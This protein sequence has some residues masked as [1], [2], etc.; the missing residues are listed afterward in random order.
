MSGGS[1]E[2]VYTHICQAAQDVAHI[3]EKTKKRD[4]GDFDFDANRMKDMTAEKLKDQVVSLMEK[5]VH[6]L[7]EAEVYA[8]RVEWLDSG[9][10]G[11]DSFVERTAEELHEVN[12]TNLE[13]EQ[14]YDYD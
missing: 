9:D 5:A 6:A 10:D 3:L 11:F 7:R 13:V 12:T 1:M 8:R 2:Y 14:E 4:V